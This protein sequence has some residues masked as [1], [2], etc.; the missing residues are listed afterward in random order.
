MAPGRRAECLWPAVAPVDN[1]RIRPLSLGSGL[2][3]RDASG[4]RRDP[5]NARPGLD[6]SRCATGRNDLEVR[7]AGCSCGCDSMVGHQPS[8]WNLRS[9]DAV[10]PCLRWVGRR[11]RFDGVDG[12]LCDDRFSWRGLERRKPLSIYLFGAD[13]T[14]QCCVPDVLSPHMMN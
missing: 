2:L 12:V 14:D 6:L 7:S 13:T 5:N 8:V 1:S 10:W 3:D 4:L 11:D 9:Q